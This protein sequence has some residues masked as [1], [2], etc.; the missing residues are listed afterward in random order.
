MLVALSGC[1]RGAGP[2]EAQP[3][4]EPEPQILFG[5]LHVHTTYSWDSFLFSLPIS[6]GEGA[7]PPDDACD[8]ARYC[9]SLD[10]FAITD[11]AE[12]LLP[13]HWEASKES[14]RRCNARAGDERDPD[15][16]AFMGFEWSQTAATPEEH[17]GHRCV[18][19]PGTS[20]EEL[21][22]RPIGAVDRGPTF[23]RMA[24]G[25]R[26]TSESLDEPA[27]VTGFAEYLESLSALPICEAGADSRSLPATCRELA[28][29]PGELNEK[30]GQWGL[31]ALVIP[32]GTAWGLYTPATTSMAKQLTPEHYDPKRERLIPVGLLI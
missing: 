30:L 15:I 23:E 18:I 10:F 31:E 29:T 27:P 32:H 17:W 7:H 22:A 5:D 11:H 20:D 25:M 24:A 28:A 16:V 13:E 14:V 1:D 26:V 12:S 3:P 19:Y 9:A 6:G 4:P 8:F 2:S 21:P